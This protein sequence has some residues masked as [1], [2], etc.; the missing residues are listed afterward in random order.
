[1]TCSHPELGHRH[2]R[3]A[4]RLWS[5]PEC[6]H[7][8]PWLAQRPWSRPE[9][10]HRHPRLA[11]KP[12]SHPKCGH[13]HPPEGRHPLAGTDNP[14]GHRGH[15]L[16]PSVGT[17]TPG[18]ADIPWLVQT[19]LAG[20]EAVVSPRVWAQTPPSGQTCPGWHRHPRW[21]QRPWSHPLAG[22]DTPGWHRGHG[23]THTGPAILAGH[24]GVA[25]LTLEAALGILAPRGRVAGGV[26]FILT[27]IDV[28]THDGRSVP[29]L[30]APPQ[31][32]S[33][34]PVLSLVRSRGMSPQ[35]G[36]TPPGSCPL[37]ENTP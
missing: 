31:E 11:Q 6:R 4:Q 18:R 25:A 14:R 35:A 3:L 24:M 28:C 32:A 19:P 22:T 23:L 7:R 34:S 29:S 5:H 17:D 9:C 15:G 27:L 30:R 10:G 8:H 36:A 26:H 21:A 12:W 37:K 20:T 2:P 33:P 13:R 16:T 1:M